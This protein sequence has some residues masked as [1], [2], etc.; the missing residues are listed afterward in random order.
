MK[1][2]ARSGQPKTQRA[3]ADV[4][5]VRTLMCSDQRLGVRIIAEELNMG[6]CL[7]EKTIPHY[8]SA[9]VHDA[10]RVCELLA[11]KFIT[12]MDHPAIFGTFQT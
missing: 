9:P 1:D 12:K 7:E 3:D 8:D 10:S 2:V 11:K 4:D 5:R 6:I